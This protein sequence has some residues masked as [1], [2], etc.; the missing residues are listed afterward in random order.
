MAQPAAWQIPNPLLDLWDLSLWRPEYRAL[1]AAP[2]DGYVLILIFLSRTLLCLGH[3]D[4]ARSKMNEA[5]VE[6]RRL[7][8]ISLTFALCFS[9][10][11]CDWATADQGSAAEMLARSEQLLALSNEHGFPFGLAVGLIMR[12]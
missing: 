6:A 3:L 11:S 9:W 4:E 10:H 2:E 1:W 12:G 7:S 5:L 8:P